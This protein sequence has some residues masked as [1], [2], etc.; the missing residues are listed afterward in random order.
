MNN[1]TLHII[2]IG[3]IL[4]LSIILQSH[5]D[6]QNCEN[7]LIVKTNNKN[8]S[9]FINNN[10]VSFGNLDTVLLKGK[11]VIKAKESI[12][13]WDS[14]T[15]TDTLNLTECDEVVRF[16]YNFEEDIYFDTNPQNAAVYQADSLLG[17]TPLFLNTNITNIKIDK[18][19]YAPKELET[20]NNARTLDLAFIGEKKEF[21]F[22]ESP[23]KEILMGSA[24]VLGAASAYF[25]LKAN[26]K[27]ERYLDTRDENYLDQ[28]NNLDL[29]SGI[30]FGALQ[31]NFGVLIYYF[32]KY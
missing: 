18:P 30:A 9:I 20:L 3:S 29:Y 23:L 7:K 21:S 8:S 32:L 11:Y 1:F 15:F 10:L 27:Y 2:F 17:Y 26:D 4:L 28:T 6:A 12:K 19:K 14:E 31:I 24:F 16:E 5:S 22:I 25:K 13:T